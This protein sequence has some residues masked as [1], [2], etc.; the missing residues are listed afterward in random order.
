MRKRLASYFRAMHKHTPK[1]RVLVSKINSID[2]LVTGT[3]KEAL[4][5]E[6][7]L[8]KKHRPRYNVVLRDDKQYVLFQLD[9]KSEYPRLRMTRKVVRDGSV[10]FGPYTSSYFARETWKILGKVFPL[11]KC[12]DSAFRNRVRPCLYHDIGQCLGPCVNVV[13]RQD[14][15]EL[16]HQVEMLLSG[17]AGGSDRFFAPSDG[18]SFRC[19][20]FRKRS[21]VSRSDQS[22]SENRGKTIC[23]AR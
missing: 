16:V 1:T 21:Q 4:L 15:M 23:G 22:H 7:S 12:S 11:R 17:K 8:I 3:E 18:R 5:L 9:K 14:Y 6:A 13:P 10:Y 20:G 2:T 19:I